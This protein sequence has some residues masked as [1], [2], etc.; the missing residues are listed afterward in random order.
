M[1][2]KISRAWLKR[3]IFVPIILTFGC[4]NPIGSE[5]WGDIQLNLNIELDKD[6][7]GFY[8]LKVDRNN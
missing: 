3:L 8:L 4:V 2:K 5:D 6:N 7:N 1:L